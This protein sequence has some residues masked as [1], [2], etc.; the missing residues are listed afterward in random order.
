V[1]YWEIWNEPDD[2]LYW[3]PQ[4]EMLRYTSLL[5]E[6]YVQAKRIDPACKILNGGLS[7]SITL[8]LKRIYKN[9]GGGYFD[10][11]AIHPFVNPLND[12]DVARIGGLY[13]GCKKI[14]QENNDDKKIWLTELGSPGVRHP[15][16][17]NSWWMGLS[18]TEEQ[19][20]EWVEK[21]YTKIL[22]QL[23]DCE[24]IFWAFFRDC[25]S[26][27]NNGIDYF[28]LLRWDYSRKPAFL[29]YKKCYENWKKSH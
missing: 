29:S 21:I 26:H 11:L 19:Q 27:W 4:D 2:E 10:I 17:A 18:P 20:A 7:K 6:V 28:G 22:P 23:P 25:K 3:Q 8:S 12:I 13:K 16:N 15:D 9:G 1:K 14:M 24:V 5:Q